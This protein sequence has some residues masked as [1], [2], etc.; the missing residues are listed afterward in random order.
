M[1]AGFKVEVCS[2]VVLLK[3]L[4][5]VYTKEENQRACSDLKATKNQGCWVLPNNRPIILEGLAWAVV[6]N[7]HQG[8]HMGKTAL[9]SALL[10]EVYINKV[11]PF[12]AQASQR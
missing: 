9:A 11:H 1:P 6:Q 8:T 12:A 7:A 3:E 5:P 4:E 10:R 2:P